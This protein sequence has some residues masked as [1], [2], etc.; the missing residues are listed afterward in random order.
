[1]SRLIGRAVK[2]AYFG[3]HPPR[4]PAALRGYADS[5]S[6]NPLL[7]GTNLHVFDWPIAVLTASLPPSKRDLTTL[8]LDHRKHS[9]LPTSWL[10]WNTRKEETRI[11]HRNGNDVQKATKDALNVDLQD[12]NVEKVCHA[13]YSMRLQYRNQDK[14]LR[15]LESLWLRSSSW[16]ALWTMLMGVERPACAF[17]VKSGKQCEVKF[18]EW[19]G[20]TIKYNVDSMFRVQLSYVPE[21]GGGPASSN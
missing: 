21:T 16:F 10:W 2:P 13:S 12:A 6:R 20:L 8:H 11:Q 4:P 14:C 9:T 7:F 5:D 15:I 3:Q 19:D 18:P 17:C 1:V